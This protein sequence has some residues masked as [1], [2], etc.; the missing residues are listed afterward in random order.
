MD[1]G[2][3]QHSLGD[4]TNCLKTGW[5]GSVLWIPVKQL[6][7]KKNTDYQYQWIDD[8]KSTRGQLV[9]QTFWSKAQPNGLNFEQCVTA[10]SIPG[11]VI[12]KDRICS[13]LNCFICS[14]P[15]VQN[16]YFRG[17]TKFEQKYSLSWSLQSS[18]TK[19][20]FLG[21]RT[22]RIVWY[23]MEEKS[24]LVSKKQNLTFSKHPFGV[25]N[26]KDSTGANAIFTNV[27]VDFLNSFSNVIFD[28]DIL[29]FTV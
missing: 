21:Q 7:S 5:I 28:N 10:Q 15:I 2:F 16:Y 14:I 20:E 6:N 11:N 1:V 18:K 4:S 8:R 13:G 12:W 27:C 24:N 23:P 3:Y 19:I 17:Q 25:M 9:N 22:G 26:F 29:S